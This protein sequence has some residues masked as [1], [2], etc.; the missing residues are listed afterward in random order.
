LADGSVIFGVSRRD[1]RR[2]SGSRRSPLANFSP[3]EL[4]CRFILPSPSPGSRG[5]VRSRR[6]RPSPRSPRTGP[7]VRCCCNGSPRCLMVTGTRAGFTRS[8]WCWRSARPRSWR[9]WPRSPRSPA[10]PVTSRPSY[11]SSSTVHH[12]PQTP[13]EWEQWL[14][15]SR[16]AIYHQWITPQATVLGDDGRI[17]SYHL[18]H[19]RCL[20][21]HHAEQAAARR[22]CTAREPPGLA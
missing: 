4:R 10:R 5:S 3:P 7:G 12:E 20:S 1:G 9:T 8:R 18:V 2:S 22:V 15:L 14:T 11:S 13:R 17:T 21:R 6:V 19:A 16:K